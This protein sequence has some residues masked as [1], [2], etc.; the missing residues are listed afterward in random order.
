VANEVVLRHFRH[1][2][3]MLK[4]EVHVRIVGHD[5]VLSLRTLRQASAAGW[6]VA[7]VRACVR[8][9]MHACMRACLL[10]VRV[11]RSVGASL[12]LLVE[13]SVE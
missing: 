12:L 5:I 4:D 13:T 2:K 1:Y 6:L 9:C 3:N 11:C 8:A 10:S 7:C